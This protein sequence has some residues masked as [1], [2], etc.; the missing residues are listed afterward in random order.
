MQTPP[1]QGALSGLVV[2]DLSR[3][4]AGPT[5]T[6]ILGD[7][8]AEVIKIE[9]PGR[10]DDTR[11][12]G[13]PFLKDTEGNE[14]AESAYYLSSNRNKSSVAID[15]ASDEGQ[16]LIAGLAEKADIFVE[17]FKVGDLKRRGL[18]YETLKLRNPRLIYCS[19]S[20]FGQTGPY[21][22]R[23]GYDFLIQGMGGI[24]SLT[25][26]PDEEGGTETKCGTGIADVMCGMYATVSI[27]AALNHRHVS[28][29]GQHI[30]ISLLDAQVSWLI[31]Q[32]VAHL[33]S[34]IVPGRL[35]NGHPTIVPYETFPGAD[36]A[37]T[38]AVGNDSQFRKFCTVAGAAELADDPLFAKNSDRV[39]NR[40]KLIPLLRQLTIKKSA[41][42]W[43][44]VLEDVGVPCGPVNDLQQVFT[45]PQ[46]LHRGMKIDLPHPVSGS[47]GLI[48]SP[49]KLE[50]TPVSYRNAPPVLGADTA[51]VLSRHLN[52]SA[53]QISDLVQ[54]GVLDTGAPTSHKDS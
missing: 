53:G 39:R 24:M 26:F 38:L 2:L 22:H 32:G 30:D 48:G 5:C 31:N 37:F 35:G 18:D 3:I 29:E 16:A 17:N 45:D 7:L 40:K 23:A 6:Q 14:T 21:A 52:L 36:Q 33:I 43:I 46:I 47:V 4:L 19:I 25:G 9:R 34:G 1:E 20:G 49:I 51:D 28:G 11:G 54:K 27:L 12:W 41:A 15:L 50:K 13:P 44:R 42:D 8:G 10:G